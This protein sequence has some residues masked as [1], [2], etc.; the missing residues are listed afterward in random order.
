M[1]VRAP[2]HRLSN[3]VS[4]GSERRQPA[5][6]T[7]P[8]A[9]SPSPGRLTGLDAAR[10][11]AILGMLAVNIG[12]LA[13]SGV[14]GKT[15]SLSHGRASLLFVLLAG[16]GYTLLTRHARRGGALPWQ[17]VLWRS[18][19]LLLIG[20]SLQLLDHGSDVILM[21]Y[22]ALFLV[23]LVFVRAPSWLL[24]VSTGLVAVA[25]P[26]LWLLAQFGGRKFDRA[27]ASL[28]DP[29]GQIVT[30]TFLTGPYPVITWLAP[31]LFGM[32]LGRRRLGERSV[33][34]RLLMLGAVVALGA[35]FGARG[36][37]AWVGQPGDDPGWDWAT[38]AAA[39]SQMPLWLVASSGAAVFVLGL[40]LLVE[41]RLGP[42]GRPL[43]AVGQLALTVYALH[44][45]I[46]AGLIHPGPHSAAD[47]LLATMLVALALATGAWAW[48]RFFSRGPLEA[49]LRV[50]PRIPYR[51]RGRE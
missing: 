51:P 34:L 7:S 21:T 30:S 2:S 29:P 4:T 36:L 19:W 17:Q 14:A 35:E 47:G 1:P 37:E 39:H 31:F 40:S 43:V 12:P 23:A 9:G 26:A 15:I 18:V 3:D 25:G 5:V 22:A 50:Q 16:I 24:L 48:R 10:A 28:I 6:S 13:Q 49:L 44:L 45:V 11:L 20:L 27:P 46:I 8:A 32:W 42:L 38:S 33:Q 41:P